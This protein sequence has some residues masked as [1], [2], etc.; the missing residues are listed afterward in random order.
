MSKFN[1]GDTVKWKSQAA[2]SAVVKVGKIIEVVPSGQR[3]KKLGYF[4]DARRYGCDS[5]VVEA[6]PVIPG[7]VAKPARLGKAQVYWPLTVHLRA[8]NGGTKPGDLRLR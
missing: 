7:S 3:P 5:Y 1:I 2:G 4:T 8:W 6:Q